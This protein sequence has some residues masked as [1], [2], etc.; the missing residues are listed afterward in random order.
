MTEIRHRDDSCYLACIILIVKGT[1]C[2]DGFDF[3]A[4]CG[5]AMRTMFANL[6]ALRCASCQSQPIYEL[7]SPE[8]EQKRPFHRDTASCRV[9][10][11][12]NNITVVQPDKI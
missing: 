10:N 9:K 8:N 1:G 3:Y 6:G 4:D 5:R 12:G 2:S 11:I 7:L